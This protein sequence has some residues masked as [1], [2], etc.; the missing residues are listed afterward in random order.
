MR[1]LLH[2]VLMALGLVVVAPI[3]VRAA[4]PMRVKEVAWNDA[5]QQAI[6]ENFTTEP[7]SI[8]QLFRPTAP[9]A[10]QMAEI[11]ASIPSG[12]EQTPQ[13]INPLEILQNPQANL[14]R[15]LQQEPRKPAP[16]D[17]AEFFKLPS[18]P[19]GI[20]LNVANF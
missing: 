9:D 12:L 18:L 1:N 3:A 4:E 19:S 8:Q 10:A 7:M 6:A 16:A 2:I 5:Y 13:V 14:P 15:Y 17:P 20:K 11:A